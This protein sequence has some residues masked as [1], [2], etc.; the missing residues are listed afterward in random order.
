MDEKRIQRIQNTIQGEL[1]RIIQEEFDI[2]PKTLISITK[3]E[4]SSDKQYATIGVSIFPDEE[5]DHAIDLLKKG[6]GYLGSFLEKRI[7]MYPIPK[8]HFEY[9]KTIAQTSRVYALMTNNKQHKTNNED[10]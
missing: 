9:D 8:L 6:A 4:M 10:A 5:R 2:P 1:G 3:V 7:R